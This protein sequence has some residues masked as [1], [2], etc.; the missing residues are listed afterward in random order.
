MQCAM[1][2]GWHVNHVSGNSIG[3]ET[4]V[5]HAVHQSQ[6]RHDV[7]R[8]G[9]KS[10][11]SIDQVSGSR[12]HGTHTC[13]LGAWSRVSSVPVITD[14]LSLHTDLRVIL[15]SGCVGSFG[16]FF[17]AGWSSMA[18]QYAEEVKLDGDRNES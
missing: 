11:I 4:V 10:V 7:E 2:R 14:S 1:L 13:K 15:R 18:H 9:C 8:V 3:I 6:T 12:A 17:C 16:D 5:V